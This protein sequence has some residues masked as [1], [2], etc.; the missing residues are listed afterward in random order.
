MINK[1]IKQ[2]QLSNGSKLETMQH[3]VFFRYQ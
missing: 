3:L 1:Y 2:L